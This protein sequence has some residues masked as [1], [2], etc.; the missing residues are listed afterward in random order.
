M[1]ERD[2]AAVALQRPS[3]RENIGGVFRAADA[4]D[5]QLVVLGG[6]ILP[7]DPLGHPTDTTQAWR[8]M[9]TV[10]EENVLDAVPNECTLVAVER[11]EEG[12]PLPEFVHPERAMY[13]FGPENGALDEATLDRCQHVVC[14]PGRACSNL[15]AA[16]NVVLYDRVAKRWAEVR[17]AFP[18]QDGDLRGVKGGYDAR[19]DRDESPGARLNERSK[20]DSTDIE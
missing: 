12:T 18:R 14:I 4:D 6:G 20:P 19:L 1:I 5:V 17:Y 11:V 8:W 9:P 13:V 3:R 7:P 16:V 10:F 15:A 2:F